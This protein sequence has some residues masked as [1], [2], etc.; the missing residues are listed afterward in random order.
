MTFF[1]HNKKYCSQQLRLHKVILT[2]AELLQDS[3]Y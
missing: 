3:N 2:F 1:L